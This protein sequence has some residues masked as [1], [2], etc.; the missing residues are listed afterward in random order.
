LAQAIWIQAPRPSALKRAVMPAVG[1]DDAANATSELYDH[2]IGFLLEYQFEVFVCGATLASMATCAFLYIHYS[3]VRLYPHQPPGFAIYENLHKHHADLQ[4]TGCV[5]FYVGVDMLVLS[6]VPSLKVPTHTMYFFAGVFGITFGVC[7]AFGHI[8]PHACRKLHGLPSTWLTSFASDNVF[9]DFTVPVTEICFKAMAQS[10]LFSVYVYGLYNTLV[11][12]SHHID[13]M[14]WAISVVAVQFFMF[15]ADPKTSRRCYLTTG[16]LTEAVLSHFGGYTCFIRTAGGDWIQPFKASV[17][18]RLILHFVLNGLGFLLIWLT[19]PV[20]V[21]VADS[22]LD[23][24]MNL[25]AVTFLT[26]LDDVEEKIFYIKFEETGHRGGSG[27]GS[28]VRSPRAENDP[29]VEAN[30]D[31]ADTPEMVAVPSWNITE[32]KCH[33]IA[34]AS[35]V[36]ALEMEN[37]ELKEQLARVLCRLAVLEGKDVA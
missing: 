31:A 24:I 37:S 1:G 29:L 25:Y 4:N 20:L 34:V 11:Y 9:L 13:F 27:A 26:N 7:M 12:S 36:L 6:L 8:S 10:A 28:V 14:Y 30:L 15:N 23:Y 32:A 33:K 5:V 21:A 19:V 3:L 18:L 22:P 16:Y 35:R 2:G 17:I